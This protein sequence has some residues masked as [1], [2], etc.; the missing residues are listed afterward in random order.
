MASGALNALAL[1]G[2]GTRAADHA[3]QVAGGVDQFAVRR[4]HSTVGPATRNSVEN[5]DRS[6]R[7]IFWESQF[8][9]KVKKV[10][11]G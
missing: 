7:P 5:N 4:P 10:E 3:I 2:D 11:Q 8:Y 1:R 9:Y 6:Q